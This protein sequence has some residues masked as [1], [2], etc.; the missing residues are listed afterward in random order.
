MTRK[1]LFATGNLNK[2][3]EL[4]PLAEP[5]FSLVSLTDLGISANYEETGSTFEANSIGKSQYYS[6]L[7]DLPV[8]A[9]DSG[10]EIDALNGDPGVFSARYLGKDLSYSERC[11]A[12]L[13]KL[14]NFS[15]KERT[16]R[17]CCVA[18]CSVNGAVIA[19][20]LGTVEGYIALEARGGLGFG[21]DPIFFY[22]PFNRTFAE[23]PLEEKNRVSHR[24]NAF[25]F[26][27][28]KLSIYLKNG[29]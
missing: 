27:F 18:S 9:D 24:F 14:V 29:S 12:I 22:P 6:K 17:F 11:T 7:V 8:V 23:I 19:S 1:L 15:E 20:S 28:Q 16:A 26:L 5:L 13:E 21:Y 4:K 2:L 3:R 25:Q 10:L